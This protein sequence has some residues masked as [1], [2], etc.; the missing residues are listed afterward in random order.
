[1]VAL[2]PGGVF[3]NQEVFRLQREVGRLLPDGSK[4]GPRKG[5]PRTTRR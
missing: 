5:Y 1:M 4:L 3:P 2:L